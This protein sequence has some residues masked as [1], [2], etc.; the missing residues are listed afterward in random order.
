MQ[1]Y[2]PFKPAALSDEDMKNETSDAIYFSTVKDTSLIAYDIEKMH[3]ILTLNF[4]RFIDA[5]HDENQVEATDKKNEI[6]QA[7]GKLNDQELVETLHEIGKNMTDTMEFNFYGAYKIDFSA[8]LKIKNRKLDFELELPS[9]VDE[10]NAGRFDLLHEAQEKLP[11]IFNS[12]RFVDYLLSKIDNE[13][14]RE[15]LNGPESKFHRF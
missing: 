11:N 13:L 12:H 1:F 15:E 10:L 3:Q 8:L 4:F 5:L 14:A 7:L 2:L 9:L 6:Y